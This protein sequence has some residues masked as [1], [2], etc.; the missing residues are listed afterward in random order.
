[1]HTALQPQHRGA[2]YNANPRPRPDLL[3]MPLW[4]WVRGGRA[5]PAASDAC[6]SL[7]PSASRQPGLVL[8][9]LMAALG[10]D[11]M[12]LTKTE[13]RECPGYT[14]LIKARLLPAGSRLQALP[15]HHA[16]PADTAYQLALVHVAEPV[17]RPRPASGSSLDQSQPGWRTSQDSFFKYQ[18]NQKPQ[19]IQ[20]IVSMYT[21]YSSPIPQED[22]ENS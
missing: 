9:M 14:S 1:M 22:K 20:V 5:P 3:T 7:T 16:L 17:G 15:P 11:G 2:S 18:A 13:W 8:G 6:G 4:A 21:F 12:V 19:S 10:T